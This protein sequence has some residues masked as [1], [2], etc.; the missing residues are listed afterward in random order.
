MSFCLIY[1]IT[2]ETYPTQVRGIAF[3]LA[4]TFGRFGTI[5]ASLM[6]ETSPEVF[7]WI[8][9]GLSVTIILCTFWLKETKGV[10]LRDKI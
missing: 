7:M 9:A 10:E 5:C 1:V 6:T 3:G 4:N 2:T 8:S